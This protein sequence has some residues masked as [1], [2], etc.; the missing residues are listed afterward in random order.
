MVLS[1]KVREMYNQRYTINM[2][3]PNSVPKSVKKLQPPLL[4][5]AHT[6]AIDKSYTFFAVTSVTDLIVKNCFTVC[7]GGFHT[8]FN[9]RLVRRFEN[10]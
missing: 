1:E 2:N 9:Q 6:R 10:Q 8:D 3:A 7:Y 4:T 5:R